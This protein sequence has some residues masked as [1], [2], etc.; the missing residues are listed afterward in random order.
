MKRNNL[1][2]LLE[3][4]VMIAL[5][6]ILSLITVIKMPFGGGITAASMV[7]I[8]LVSYR[9][10]VKWGVLIAFVYSALQ[11]LLGMENLQYATSFAAACAII[12]LDYVIAFAVLGLGGIFR[13]KLHSQSL[14]VVCG[15][16]LACALRYVCHVIAGCTVWAGV[17]IPT[18]DGLLYSVVY[19]AAYMIPE[20]I[21]TIAGVWYLTK[22]IDFRGDKIV[23]YK[24]ESGNGLAYV[25]SGIGMLSLLLGIV[26]D[27][28]YC[29][30]L[31]QTE[32]GFD[33][34]GIQNANFYFLL[35]VIGS[36]ILLWGIFSLIS[37]KIKRK[38]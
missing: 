20:T 11:L 30:K 1:L 24:K 38:I 10:K 21:I 22:M 23:G 29:F 28:L 36:G 37:K 33:V 25:F 26:I 18:A 8:I 13:D 5:A 7:P 19:N 31:M 15:S 4:A 14:E 12:F 16:A 3:G 32:E 6:T 2:A 9:R 35:I 27:A 17:S 34:T